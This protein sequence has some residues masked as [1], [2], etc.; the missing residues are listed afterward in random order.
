MLINRLNKSIINEINPNN[1]RHFRSC[2]QL[3]NNDALK[4]VTLIIK[5]LILNWVHVKGHFFADDLVA[6]SAEV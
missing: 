4:V 5:A 6:N 3:H 1:R 2:N